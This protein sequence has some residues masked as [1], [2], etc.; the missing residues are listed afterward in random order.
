MVQLAANAGHWL[1]RNWRNSCCHP[2]TS[3][4]AGVG[5]GWE[6][7]QSVT[8]SVLITHTTC[9]VV[10]TAI[11]SSWMVLPIANLAPWTVKEFSS[12]SLSF[13]LSLH[14]DLCY[15]HFL[16]LSL[17][18][19]TVK[20]LKTERNYYQTQAVLLTTGKRQETSLV[21]KG[22]VV[23]FR[24]PATWGEDKFLYKNQ[25]R[26]FCSTTNI[27]KWRIIWGRRIRVFLPSTVYRFSSSGLLMS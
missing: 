6:Q 19:V 7:W 2:S 21:W 22:N 24:R 14:P 13:S 26:R 25:L 11:N 15:S 10:N 23:L 16:P 4:S 5:K 27:F 20:R 18:I 12:L 1:K 8:V 9:S 17:E 3:S